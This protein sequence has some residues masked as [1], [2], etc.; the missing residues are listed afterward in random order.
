MDIQTYP[1]ALTKAEHDKMTKQ[2][3]R[4]LT[5]QRRWAGYSSQT[6]RRNETNDR[7]ES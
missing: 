5:W 1:E 4:P 3:D 2:M 6:Y 7:R